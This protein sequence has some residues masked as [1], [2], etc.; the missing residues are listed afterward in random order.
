MARLAD[1]ESY[2]P[3]AGEG[4]PPWLPMKTAAAGKM[5]RNPRRF[6]QRSF[7]RLMDKWYDEA[8]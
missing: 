2:E 5:M 1:R 6:V 7:L 3:A 8:K 4:S